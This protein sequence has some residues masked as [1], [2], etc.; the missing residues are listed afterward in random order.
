MS[1]QAVTPLI[2][3]RQRMGRPRNRYPNPA[4]VKRKTVGGV[5]VSGVKL[6]NIAQAK[7]LV[8]WLTIKGQNIPHSWDRNGKHPTDPSLDLLFYR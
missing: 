5:K 8:G 3:R 4:D 6:T 1:K 7:R 2:P